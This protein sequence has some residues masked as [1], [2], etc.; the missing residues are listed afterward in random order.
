MV[1]LLL[2]GYPTLRH[3]EIATRLMSE[4]RPNVATK[5]TLQPVSYKHFIIA[6]LTQK[7]CF[8]LFEGVY[9]AKF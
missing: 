4:V 1:V 2:L 6:L 5:P 9:I 8:T 7:E 3:N